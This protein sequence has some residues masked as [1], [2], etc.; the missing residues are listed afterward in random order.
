[1]PANAGAGTNSSFDLITSFSIEYAANAAFLNSTFQVVTAVRGQTNYEIE[2]RNSPSFVIVK[3][4]KYFFRVSCT[5]KV[6]SSR[7]SEAVLASAVSIPTRPLSLL[8]SISGGGVLLSWFLPLDTGV[9]FSN[10]PLK[11]YVLE[12]DTNGF[13]GCALLGCDTTIV[14]ASRLTYRPNSL[15]TGTTYF[16][17]IYA[18]NDAGI[19]PPSSIVSVMAKSV[20]TAPVS[21]SAS[22]LDASNSALITWSLPP[23][24]GFGI[25][26]FVDTYQ[27]DC[28]LDNQ[29]NVFNSTVVVATSA[30]FKTL[31]R[32]MTY[33]FRVAA[34]NIAGMGQYSRTVSLSINIRPTVVFA[35]IPIFSALPPADGLSPVAPSFGGATLVVMVRDTPQL[36]NVTDRCV[37]YFGNY[38]LQI[39]GFSQAREAC[40]DPSLFR[41]TFNLTIPPKQ[42]SQ[43]NRFNVIISFQKRSNSINSSFKFQYLRSPDTY[44][45]SCLPSIASSS[46][47]DLV[48]LSIQN[49]GRISSV[50]DIEIYP[51]SHSYLT[52]PPKIIFYSS[53]LTTTL[54][55]FTTGPIAA[56]QVVFAVRNKASPQAVC[57]DT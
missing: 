26:G 20:P 32:G 38:T 40:S 47:G 8:G 51:V 18:Q 35:Y 30:S 57:A 5:N 10:Y 34:L 19:G 46:G 16:F 24:A 37:V 4:E 50:S 41:T 2:I 3:G 6:G 22:W 53:T 31:V 9:G 42:G 56:E 48:V 39:S 17:R 55:S 49:F 21:P 23:D 29:F 36:N 33:F 12:Q 43:A 13:A 44:V 11:N 15:T 45:S 52:T 27:V 54:V 28:S 14:N 25:P 7:M 1:V